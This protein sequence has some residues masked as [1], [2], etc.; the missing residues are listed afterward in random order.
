MTGMRRHR[1]FTLLEVL[2]VTGLLALLAGFVLPTLIGDFERARLP[3]SARQMRALLQLTRANAMIEGRRYRIRFACP[4]CEEEDVLDGQGEQR[5]PIV[6]VED[7]PLERPE[8]FRPLRAAWAQGEIFQRGVRC[9]GVRLGKPTVEA[10]LGDDFE[11]EQYQEDRQEQLELSMEERFEEDFPPLVIEA[12][13]TCEWAT[14]VLTNAPEDVEIA[15]LDPE[16]DEYRQIEVIID[17]LIGLAWL[18]RPLYEEELE[19][20]REHNW[21]PVLR[22][23]FLDPV[24]LTEDNVLEIKMSAIR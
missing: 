19:L 12:D 3:E 8:E 6:E 1:G 9:A 11:A 10:L 5:Q 2:I 24:P 16:T 21:P 4:D 18:Q 20:M 13:G 17:G 22:K 7:N 23:D 14:F 15:D